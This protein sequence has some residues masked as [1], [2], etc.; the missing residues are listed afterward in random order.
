MA[1][2][3]NL[4]N[5]ATSLDYNL[6]AEPNM[7]D[8]DL[9]VSSKIKS[10]S[11]KD[12]GPVFIKLAYGNLHVHQIHWILTILKKILT[13]STKTTSL[14]SFREG[15][16]TSLYLFR[17][18]SSP[19]TDLIILPKWPELSPFTCQKCQMLLL[20]PPVPRH[21]PWLQACGSWFKN[22]CKAIPICPRWSYLNP[23]F[24][25]YPWRGAHSKIIT[26]NLALYLMPEASRT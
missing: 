20:I 21:S 2:Q 10:Y 18:F 14:P 26:E 4:S 1:S 25:N 19:Q 3:E 23:L 13:T 6:Q 16:V 15:M 22:K 17:Y 7:S 11:K 5:G 8:D 9:L 12:S 24:T